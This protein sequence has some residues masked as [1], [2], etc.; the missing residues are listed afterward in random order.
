[1]IPDKNTCPLSSGELEIQMNTG[2]PLSYEH[3]DDDDEKLLPGV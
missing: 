2:A 3:D 1:M